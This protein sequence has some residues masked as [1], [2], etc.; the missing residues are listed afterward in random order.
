MGMPWITGAVVALAMPDMDRDFPGEEAQFW[1]EHVL[2]VFVLPLY[3]TCRDGAA[4]ANPEGVLGLLARERG[5]GVP[6][7]T[8]GTMMYYTPSTLGLLPLARVFRVNTNYMLCAPAQIRM[9]GSRYMLYWTMSALPVA[10]A[11]SLVW[12]GIA[13]ALLWLSAKLPAAAVVVAAA[14]VPV[15]SDKKKK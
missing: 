3:L 2:L 1:L 11:I 7:M 9:W 13:R 14:A 12:F 10:V 4:E 6:A 15:T 5:W 8:R